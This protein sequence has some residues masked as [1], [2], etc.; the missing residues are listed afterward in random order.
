[1]TFSGG[2]EISENRLTNAQSLGQAI[3]VFLTIIAGQFR[4]FAASRPIGVSPAA[5]TE[6]LGEVDQVLRDSDL[7]LRQ[8]PRR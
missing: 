7:A 3:A 8:F 5:L 1:V 2:S 6:A 4:A